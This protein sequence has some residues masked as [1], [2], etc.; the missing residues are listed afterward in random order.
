LVDQLGASEFR[1]IFDV[2]LPLYFV[3][4]FCNPMPCFWLTNGN[5][6]KQGNARK[7]FIH[8]AWQ[9]TETYYNKLN[10]L[11]YR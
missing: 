2:K 7:A 3:T 6:A 8:A 4:Q 1:V 10:E 11:L 5:N 9:R